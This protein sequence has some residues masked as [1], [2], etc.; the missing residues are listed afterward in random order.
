MA[1][2]GT[3]IPHALHPVHSQ[4]GDDIRPDRFTLSSHS[5]N[6]IFYF[7]LTTNYAAKVHSKNI[8]IIKIKIAV[9]RLVK[10]LV[11]FILP[12]RYL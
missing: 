7:Y 11:I 4:N 10:S 6:T 5:I 9:V 1:I 12:G 8:W 3:T 2:S